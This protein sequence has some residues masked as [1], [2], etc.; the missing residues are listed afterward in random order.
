MSQF[1]GLVSYLSL[2][3]NPG[4]FLQ[5]LIQNEEGQL[6]AVLIAACFG[7]VQS[8]AQFRA[9][10]D[11]SPGILIRGAVFGLVFLYLVAWLMRNF[12]RWFGAQANIADIRLALG[13]GLLPWLI[14]F[15]LL[16]WLSVR[17]VNPADMKDVYLYFFGLFVY[18]YV[19]LLL[20][21]RS[22]LGISLW[23]S[24][25][26]L[27]VTTLISLFPLTLIAELLLGGPPAQ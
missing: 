3:Y 8:F 16:G 26:C 27:I 21:I 20:G 25:L 22:A 1:K 4:R 24:F 14:T 19:I 15:C 11:P 10:E 13:W 17:V 18:G 2:W 7:L 5:G 12:G 6:G 23:K 9:M